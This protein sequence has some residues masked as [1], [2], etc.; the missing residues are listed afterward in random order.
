[1]SADKRS[2]SETTLGALMGSLMAELVFQPSTH[3]SALSSIEIPEQ[4]STVLL[5][6]LTY[7]SPESTPSRDT[8]VKN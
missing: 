7:P 6:E 8:S 5:Q 1:M 2:E 3:L 4:E